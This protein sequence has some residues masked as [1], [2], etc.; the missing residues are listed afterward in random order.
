[1]EKYIVK[2][3][4]VSSVIVLCVTIYKLVADLI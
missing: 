1:M 2:L 4:M 3:I